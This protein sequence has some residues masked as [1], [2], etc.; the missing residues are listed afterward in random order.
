MRSPFKITYMMMRKLIAKRKLRKAV[1]SVNNYKI[2][3][4]I[5]QITVFK[6]MI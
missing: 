4:N 3:S 6:S 1:K 2:H 5:P